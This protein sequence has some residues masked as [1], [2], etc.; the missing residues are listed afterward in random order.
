MSMA[1]SFQDFPWRP[2]LLP[3]ILSR[4]TVLVVSR[5]R[6]LRPPMTRILYQLETPV[7]EMPMVSSI[8]AMCLSEWTTMIVFLFR[9]L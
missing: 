8:F 3:R 1:L 4:W 5:F 6:D 7:A 9:E 2:R